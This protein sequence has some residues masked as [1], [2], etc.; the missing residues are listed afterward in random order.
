MD[1]HCCHGVDET[2]GWRSCHALRRTRNSEAL[3]RWLEH[4]YI[5]LLLLSY[6]MIHD[7][8]AFYPCRTVQLR[9]GLIRNSLGYIPLRGLLGAHSRRRYKLAHVLAY[10]LPHIVR[11]N[12]YASTL[13]TC[14]FLIHIR[15]IVYD[16]LVFVLCGANHA[17][18]TDHATHRLPRHV[19]R[20]DSIAEH[21]VGTLI[22]ILPIF[23]STSKVLILRNVD[24]VDYLAIGVYGR[25]DSFLHLAQ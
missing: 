15:R 24:M 18:L 6:S 9:I 14:L 4:F 3:R 5:G 1:S 7:I 23:I 16:D 20:V 19:V 11:I 8:W 12:L 10:L 22:H 25:E 21:I 13:L 2:W 17:V